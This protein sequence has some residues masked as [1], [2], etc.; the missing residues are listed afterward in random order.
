MT[1]IRTCAILSTFTHMNTD[2]NYY[3]ETAEA[4]QQVD[5]HVNEQAKHP[6]ME[7]L[8]QD[9]K[10]IKSYYIVAYKM[11][12]S[13]SVSQLW[14][15]TAIEAMAFITKENLVFDIKQFDIIKNIVEG[16]MHPK[17]KSITIQE[18]QDESF[19]ESNKAI[20]QIT[21]S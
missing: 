4:E 14:F 3:N 21:A 15:L 12:Y 1:F 9:R 8:S 2:T 16:D 5:N 13:D 10:T 6:K 11:A 18:L 17:F 7:E 19:M 20:S